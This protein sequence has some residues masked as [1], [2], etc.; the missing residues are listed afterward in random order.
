[1]KDSWVPPDPADDI[2]TSAIILL[3]VVEPISRNSA[4]GLLSHLS[5][6][7]YTSIFLFLLPGGMWNS[8]GFFCDVK[9][10]ILFK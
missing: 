1:M 8:N 7:E 6:V 5:V 4:P 9:A 10:N 2:E 3:T